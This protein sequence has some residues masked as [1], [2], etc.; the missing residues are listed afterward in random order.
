MSSIIDDFPN[1]EKCEDNFVGT[2]KIEN[3]V[4]ET[5]FFFCSEQREEKYKENNN[6]LNPIIHNDHEKNIIIVLESPHV[7]EYADKSFINPALGITG[8]CLQKYFTRILARTIDSR[9]LSLDKNTI[10]NVILMNAVQYQCSQGKDTKCFRDKF[11]CMLWF[12]NENDKNYLD[13]MNR[14]KLY[15]P[16]IIINACTIGEHYKI[17]R[18]EKLNN[19]ENDQTNK[20]SDSDSSTLKPCRSYVKNLLKISL[21]TNAIFNF[22]P[23]NVK[24]TFKLNKYLDRVGYIQ[25]RNKEKDKYNL[26][27]YVQFV[28]NEYV[29]NHKDC[30]MYQISH[31]SSARFKSSTTEIK[32]VEY[33]NLEEMDKKNKNK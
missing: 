13:F 18:E 5:D 12:S 28:I 20:T 3:N 9:I 19:N 23:K 17:P 7:E 4:L 1:K 6:T 24:T 16:S 27:T 22:N 31:P 10:Y 30:S 11:W 33:V 26:K 29:K 32:K 8:C 25:S 2:I 15:N 14:L 21:N